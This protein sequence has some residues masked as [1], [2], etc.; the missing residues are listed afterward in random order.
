MTT[1]K[2]IKDIS[3]FIWTKISRIGRTKGSGNGE[4]Y[5]WNSISEDKVRGD[6]CFANIRYDRRHN[7]MVYLCEFS[8]F[9][10]SRRRHHSHRL[11]HKWHLQNHSTVGNPGN[12]RHVSRNLEFHLYALICVI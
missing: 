2:I 12:G 3:K 4:N 7:F 6:M 1:I 10:Y 9:E 5:G 11:K 8:L